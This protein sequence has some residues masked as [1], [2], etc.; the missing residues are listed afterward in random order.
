MYFSSRTALATCLPSR[1][2]DNPYVPPVVL[3]DFQLFGKPVAIGGKSILKQPISVTKSLTLTYKQNVFGFEFSALSYANPQGNRYRYRLEGLEEQWNETD[4]SRR[5]VTYTTLAPGH[6]VF[7]V[8]GR[9]TQGPGANLAWLCALTCCHLCGCTVVCSDLRRFDSYPALA[10]LQIPVT[11]GCGCVERQ[12]GRARQ[13]ADAHRA[14]FA[15]YAAAKFPRT[16]AAFSDGLEHVSDAT[17]RS[18][19]LA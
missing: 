10:S 16:V 15:R 4:S 18:Q 1:I 3:T 9:T 7:R 6:Y 19:K 5:F 14:G 2:V 11:S 8:Q 13:R 17:G 12:D